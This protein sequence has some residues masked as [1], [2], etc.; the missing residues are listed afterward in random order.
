MRP[1]RS[2][3]LLVVSA[4]LAPLLLVLLAKWQASLETWYSPPGVDVAAFVDERFTSHVESWLRSRHED[5]A[6]A[7]LV[8][9]RECPCTAAT[10]HLLDREIERSS[11]RDIRRVVLDI[12]TESA[13][14]AAFRRVARALPS[15]PTLLVG[16]AG[17]LVYAGP[18]TTGAFCS[19]RVARVL[20]LAVLETRPN[21]PF[22][23]AL[24]RGCYCPRSRP[25][26][27]DE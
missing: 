14:R 15:T 1:S 12:D 16:Q 4:V 8:T 23:N 3:E 25:A 24:E 5:G 22:V 19:N 21:R 18:A 2:D 6:V 10:V 26:A 13:G 20:G 9:S 17:R 11:R 27:R 7:Y